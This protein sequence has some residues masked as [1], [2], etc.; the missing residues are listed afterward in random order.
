MF[1][2]VAQ[3]SPLSPTIFNLY[4]DF[5]LKEILVLNVSSIHDFQ[6]SPDLDNIIGMAFA[7]SNVIVF[8]NVKSAVIMVDLEKN[9]FNS[10][11][12]FVNP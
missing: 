3:G 11:E 4:Q 1:R 5:V 7:N 6:I 12:I 2:S 9:L 10:V 8:R